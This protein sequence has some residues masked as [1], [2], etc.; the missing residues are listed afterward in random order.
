MALEA[1]SGPRRRR[2]ARATQFHHQPPRASLQNSLQLPHY[3]N[4]ISTVLSSRVVRAGE[5][6]LAMG[7]EEAAIAVAIVSAPHSG[8]DTPSSP[9]S[10]SA[11]ST[12]SGPRACRI[13]RDS[14]DRIILTVEHRAAA[15]MQGVTLELAQ[16]DNALALE[17]DQFER[18]PEPTSVDQ[19]TT[20]VSPTRSTSLSCH[21]MPSDL[22]PPDN[23]W[24][25]EAS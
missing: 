7:R 13:R 3:S 5:A 24:P 12:T 14:D 4:S 25:K 6:C 1:F 20:A 2:P 10:Q 11:T 8:F 16:R 23:R 22:L 9:R 18:N 21:N 19:R 17:P 15:A